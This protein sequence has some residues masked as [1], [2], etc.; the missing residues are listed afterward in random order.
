MRALERSW[1]D[2][3]RDGRRS[4]YRRRGRRS[5]RRGHRRAY[6]TKQPLLR[7]HS[8]GL[9]AAGPLS[10][11]GACQ[12]ISESA[13][14]GY[15]QAYG[16]VGTQCWA[17]TARAGRPNRHGLACEMHT[18][19]RT[20]VIYIRRTASSTPPDDGG[21]RSSA[22]SAS[23]SNSEGTGADGADANNIVAV[24]PNSGLL[25]PSA[26]RLTRST[27]CPS[28]RRLIAVRRHFLGGPC[29]PQAGRPKGDLSQSGPTQLGFA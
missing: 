18:A 12:R 5:R 24:R 7:T 13:V 16:C 19:V 3:A 26:A 29:F 27:G 11:G 17:T 28:P 10:I 8:I 15:A 23:T 21:E 4:R 25:A 6:H 22:W 1:E 2:C 20:R 9:L 14:C